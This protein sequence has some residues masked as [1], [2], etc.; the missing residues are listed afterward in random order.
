MGMKPGG[1]SSARVGTALLTQALSALAEVVPALD[2][3][4]CTTS[5]VPNT[6]ATPT[7]MVRTAEGPTQT[8]KSISCSL[9][10]KNVL[11]IL[12]WGAHPGTQCYC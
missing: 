10:R 6:T 3:A 12:P 5:K 7:A 4:V 1:D 11:G 2:P 8:N 9:L